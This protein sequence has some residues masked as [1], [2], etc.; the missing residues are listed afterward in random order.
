MASD[1][2]TDQSEHPAERTTLRETL[3]FFG[4][5]RWHRVTA[6]E[7]VC[8]CGVALRMASKVRTADDDSWKYAPPESVGGC[9]DAV[10]EDPLLGRRRNDTPADKITVDVRGGAG[11]LTELT[12]KIDHLAGSRTFTGSSEARLDNLMD[13]I[14]NRS[15]RT[16]PILGTG[17]VKTLADATARI[18]SDLS[19]EE[20]AVLRKRFVHHPKGLHISFTDDGN[21]G[22]WFWEAEYPSEGSRGPFWSQGELEIAVAAYALEGAGACWMAFAQGPVPKP[23]KEIEAV[24]GVQG[25]ARRSRRARAKAVDVPALVAALPGRID[26]TTPPEKKP[27]APEPRPESTASPENDAKLD[28]TCPVC[29]AVGGPHDNEGHDG[30]ETQCDCCHARL[31]MVTCTDESAHWE[32]VEPDLQVEDHVRGIWWTSRGNSPDVVEIEVETRREAGHDTEIEVGLIIR[33]A[34][35]GPVAFAPIGAGVILDLNNARQLHMNLSAWIG[36][37]EGRSGNRPASPNLRHSDLVAMANSVIEGDTEENGFYVDID[38]AVAVAHG[39]LRL[40]AELEEFATYHMDEFIEYKRRRNEQHEVYA[41][42]DRTRVVLEGFCDQWAARHR[43][44]VLALGMTGDND[45]TAA[46]AEIGLWKERLAHQRSVITNYVEKKVV[47]TDPF[48][49]MMPCPKC[50]VLHVDVGEFATKPHH[51]H[52]CQNKKCGLVW[53]PSGAPTVGIAYIPEFINEPEEDATGIQDPTDEE[54]V[55]ARAAWMEA[56]SGDPADD[57]EAFDAWWKTWKAS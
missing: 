23:A 2:P 43:E 38:D 44:I 7:E 36:K 42:L 55:A 49:I 16:A 14:A 47:P 46:I 22:W 48:A 13:V 54:R 6:S 56:A 28:M 53:R 9:F 52:A 15:Q 39:V 5:H 41:S 3:H 32:R 20:E 4:Q 50:G 31:V 8:T 19:P 18:L 51:T 35:P 34:A 37:A 26:I 1:P 57:D 29:G 17:I 24:G 30:T 12:E 40:H 27:P 25:V 33:Q 11:T 45:H 21:G 10:S